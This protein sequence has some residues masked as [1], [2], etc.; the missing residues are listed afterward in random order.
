MNIHYSQRMNQKDFGFSL[1]FALAPPSGKFVNFCFHIPYSISSFPFLF[2]SIYYF[3]FLLIF[4]SSIFFTLCF[5][6]FNSLSPIELIVFPSYTFWIV[7][8]AIFVVLLTFFCFLFFHSFSPYILFMY[9]FHFSLCL[10]FIPLFWSFLYGT[11]TLWYNSCKFSLVSL[12]FACLFF[13]VR[14]SGTLK[15]R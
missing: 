2:F 3:Y 11:L 1:T 7:W 4:S 13:C 15:A 14:A 12:V 8:Y 10:S 5:I 9:H 6:S